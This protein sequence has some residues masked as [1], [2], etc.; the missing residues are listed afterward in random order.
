MNRYRHS[1]TSRN[2]YLRNHCIISKLAIVKHRSFKEIPLYQCCLCGVTSIHLTLTIWSQFWFSALQINHAS[3]SSVY[4]L[5]L[6]QHTWLLYEVR[7]FVWA[8]FKSIYSIYNSVTHESIRYDFDFNM[9]ALLQISSKAWA[10][11]KGMF[12]IHA[13]PSIRKYFV[14]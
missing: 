7:T 9:K 8:L 1:L 11:W 14:R 3:K 12:I 5:L 13:G 10:N 6:V 4:T 2:I